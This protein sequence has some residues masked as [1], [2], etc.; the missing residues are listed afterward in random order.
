[1]TGKELTEWQKEFQLKD[2]LTQFDFEAFETALTK[3]PLTLLL[4]KTGSSLSSGAMLRAAIRADWIISPD[5]R[6]MIDEKNGEAAYFYAGKDIN[7]MHPAVVSWLGEKI[8][9]KY[10]SILAE[11]PKNL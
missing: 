11:V 10:T 4:R 2:N 9:K 7:Q 3:M 1:M 8:D 5:C 6:A